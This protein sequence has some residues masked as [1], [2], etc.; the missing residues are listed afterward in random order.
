MC[1]CSNNYSPSPCNNCTP[2]C[3]GCQYTMNTDCVIFN[4]EKLDFEGST[5]VDNSSRTLT[6][7]LQSIGNNGMLFPSE[8]H[9]IGDGDFTL[10]SN[11]NTKTII[12]YDIEGVLGQTATITL[13]VN[14]ADYF[15]KVFTFINKTT[16]ASGTWQFNVPIVYDYD[17]ITT[18][19]LYNTLV[20][21]GSRV[22]QLA[23]IQVNPTSWAWTIVKN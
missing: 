15:N 9:H 16:T 18:S 8:F 17:P 21:A 11:S 1:N 20:T 14:S 6:S 4:K 13:P 12:L 22:L 2:V 7:V 10:D 19:P 23:F 3:A 5:I